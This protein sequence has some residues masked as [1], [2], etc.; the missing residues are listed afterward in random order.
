MVLCHN[1]PNF[2]L[3]VHMND[4]GISKGSN[5]Q[6]WYSNLGLNKRRTYGMSWSFSPQKAAA[7]F[8]REKSL[9]HSLVSCAAQWIR[10][11]SFYL[12]HCCSVWWVLPAASWIVGC[13]GKL[14]DADIC[15]VLGERFSVLYTEMRGEKANSRPEWLWSQTMNFASW[16][17]IFSGTTI[18]VLF[19]FPTS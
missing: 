12:L 9:L 5:Q 13:R 11:N 19:F 18:A 3:E 17:L 4:L 8:S 1:R 16:W 14:Q 7:G 2:T 15:G 10:S 6:L